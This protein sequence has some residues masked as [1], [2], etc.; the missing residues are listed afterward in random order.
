MTID[1]QGAE[2]GRYYYVIRTYRTD[3]E[4]RLLDYGT[5]LTYGELVEKQKEWNIPNNRVGIDMAYK[6]QDVLGACVINGWIGLNATKVDSYDYYNKKRK[7][8]YKSIRSN[9]EVS[10]DARG[11]G[12]FFKFSS[13]RMKDLVSALKSGNGLKWDV[14]Y[15]VDRDDGYY[16][17]SLN[18]E[19]KQAKSNGQFE[20]VTIRDRNDIFD[21]EC[22]N[23]GMAMYHDTFP[24]FIYTAD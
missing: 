14:P 24:E 5:K 16:L 6:T 21:A 7:K 3:G 13:N 15:D 20:W 11:L 8:T 17:N 12:R 1:K 22:M 4:S 23:L 19:V 10:R 18:S 2:G 9:I